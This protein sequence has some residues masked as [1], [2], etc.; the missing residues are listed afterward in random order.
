MTNEQSPSTGSPVGRNDPC[1]CG[2]GKKFKNCCLGKSV[3]GAAPVLR[4]P[5][6]HGSY[7]EIWSRLRGHLT[8]DVTTLDDIRTIDGGV[9]DPYGLVFEYV[10]ALENAA[11]EE[12]GA[13]ADG[14]EFCSFVLQQFRGEDDQFR[15]N[16]R[17]YLGSFHYLAG[18]PARGEEVL[19]GLIADRPHRSIGYAY[20]ADALLDPRQGVEVLREAL[21][22]PVEDAA[23]YDMAPRLKELERQLESR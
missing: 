16:L 22:Y 19:R 6:D 17:A 21:A 2:S 3:A 15:E 7:A 10:E 9:M 23:D 20:L 14:V 18:E 5:R 12:P 4:A 8:P 13:A 1:P 11:R